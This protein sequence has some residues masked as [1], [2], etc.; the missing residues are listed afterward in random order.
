MALS[1]LIVANWRRGKGHLRKGEQ[2][3]CCIIGCFVYMGV[4]NIWNR[5]SK[6]GKKK[7]A[8][9][10]GPKFFSNGKEGTHVKGSL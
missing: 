6:D 1:V 9:K 3:C 7:A 4:E 10:L 5:C 2:L 8:Y